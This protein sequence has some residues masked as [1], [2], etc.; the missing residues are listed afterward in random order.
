MVVEWPEAGDALTLIV[1]EQEAQTIANH[2]AD[3]GGDKQAEDRQIMM[4]GERGSGGDQ[5]HT[6]HQQTD[7]GQ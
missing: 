7:D 5:D 2:R 6:R 4:P 3:E 1:A